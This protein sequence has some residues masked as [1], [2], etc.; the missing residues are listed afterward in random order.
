[1]SCPGL[2]GRGED[3]GAAVEDELAALPGDQR[4]EGGKRAS[5]AGQGE[6]VAGGAFPG[7]VPGGQ[8]GQLGQAGRS[9]G[10]MPGQPLVGRA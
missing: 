6:D 7:P 5:L 10:V 8:A 3:E 4:V 9:A 2:E 1:M